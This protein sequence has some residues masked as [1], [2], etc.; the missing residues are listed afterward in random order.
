MKSTPTLP[1]S[2]STSIHG[3]LAGL[4]ALGAR[5]PAQRTLCRAIGYSMVYRPV[6]GRRA[7]RGFARLVTDHATFAYLADVFVARR[8]A[9]GRARAASLIPRRSSPSPPRQVAPLVVGHPRCG[10]P[11]PPPL[12][13][14][15]SGAGDLSQALGPGVLLAR[16]TCLV[17]TAELDL[18]FV[19][20]LA[21]RVGLDRVDAGVARW[22]RRSWTSKRHRRGSGHSTSAPP[23]FEPAVAEAWHRRGC[24]CRRWRRVRHRGS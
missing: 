11:L 12:R 5:H 9:Q 24:R 19:A 4:L 20:E 15:R 18:E 17:A 10:K 7:G 8:G 13:V 16:M 2:I 21:D 3:F 1:G 6:S 22:R 14:C 23:I